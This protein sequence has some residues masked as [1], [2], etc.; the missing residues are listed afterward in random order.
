MAA[1]IKNTNSS[2]KTIKGTLSLNEKRL[3]TKFFNFGLKQRKHFHCRNVPL[4]IGESHR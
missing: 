2:T 1:S 4:S 3:I